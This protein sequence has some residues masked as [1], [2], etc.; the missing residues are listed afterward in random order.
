MEQNQNTTVVII[1]SPKSMGLGI[2]LTLLFGPLGMLYST[3]LGGIIMLVLGIPL[4]VFTF[5]I[6]L[7]IVWPIAIIWTI[8]A[9]NSYN[10]KL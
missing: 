5:G 1:K 6:G 2:L 3:I 4:V 8:V 7:A 10:R 9:V